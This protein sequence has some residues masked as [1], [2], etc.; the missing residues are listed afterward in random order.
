M[1]PLVHPVNLTC[2]QPYICNNLFIFTSWN[3]LIVK[4]SSRFIK[5]VITYASYPGFELYGIENFNESLNALFKINGFVHNHIEAFLCNG[6]KPNPRSLA[7]ALVAM[8]TSASL[9]IME[10]P[11][12]K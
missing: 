12:S 7:M 2:S 10:S 6:T 9:E 3:Q 8:P 11:T 1:L 5:I 4:D